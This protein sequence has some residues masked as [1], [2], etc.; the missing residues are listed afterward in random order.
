MSNV[1]AYVQ[2]ETEGNLTNGMTVADLRR[3]RQ[4]SNPNAQV[5]VKVAA[6]AFLDY[7]FERLQ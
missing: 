7:F 2:V 5:C 6:A 3:D 1:D 4:P